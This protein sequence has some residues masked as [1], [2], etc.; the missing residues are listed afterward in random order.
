MRTTVYLAAIAVL[1]AW[2]AAPAAAQEIPPAVQQA[3]EGDYKKICNG[4]V[5]G[6]GRILACM[7]AKNSELSQGCRT[8]L[9]AEEQKRGK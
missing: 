2:H 1:S 5:P 8:A 4:V 6:G 7:K 9:Q 3:C